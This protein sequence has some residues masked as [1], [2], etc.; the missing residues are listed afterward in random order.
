MN[1]V[2]CRGRS[3]DGLPRMLLSRPCLGGLVPRKKL[4]ARFEK[5]FSGQRKSWMDDSTDIASQVAAAQVRKRRGQN[6]DDRVISRTATTVRER[7]PPESQSRVPERPFNSEEVFCRNLRSARK[8][9]A[10]TRTVGSD[11]WIPPTNFGVGW[12]TQVSCVMSQR[13]LPDVVCT[14]WPFKFCEW[15]ASRL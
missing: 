12:G 2:M 10:S 5:F 8:G 3:E 4:E 9:A 7:L 14:R 1:V 13:L 6:S 11:L 15:D